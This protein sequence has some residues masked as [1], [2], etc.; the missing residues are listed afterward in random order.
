VT[1]ASGLG[2]RLPSGASLAARGSPRPLVEGALLAATT[3]V[4][5][6][7]GT[8]VP[9]VG[10]LFAFV[11]PV[12]VALAYLRHGPRVAVLSALAAAMV[13]AALVGP[14]QAAAGVGT[15]GSLGLAFGWSFRRRAPAAVA[16]AAGSAAALLSLLAGLAAARLVMHQDLLAQLLDAYRQAAA[17]VPGLYARLG[18]PAPVQAQ[19]RS[20]LQSALD[21]IPALLPAILVVAAVG[22]AAVSH[23][24]ARRVLARFG[25]PVPGLPPFAAWRVPPPV[26]AGWLAA[27]ALAYL[28]QRTGS[29]LLADAALDVQYLFSLLYTVLGLSVAYYLLRRLGLA[30]GLAVAVLAAAV[31][32]PLA[33]QVLLWLGLVESVFRYRDVLEARMGVR[34]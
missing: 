12:P 22:M 23:A 32:S 7:A 18:V 5:V 16:V 24:V 3:V 10:G 30:R 25:H 9:L 26:A 14:L 33:A 2:G 21:A 15:F 31:G 27:P 8:Y 28:G 1:G 13:L 34:P 17:T 6:L 29:G 20:S 4:L 19:V 11:L